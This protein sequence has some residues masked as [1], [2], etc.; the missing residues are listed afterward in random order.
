MRC[1]QQDR[2]RIRVYTGDG[3]LGFE[4]DGTTTPEALALALDDWF[5]NQASKT[6][7]KPTPE[8]PSIA[9]PKENTELRPQACREAPNR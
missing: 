4:T 9:E 8:K 2:D 3:A 6:D 1:I 7:A 5:S